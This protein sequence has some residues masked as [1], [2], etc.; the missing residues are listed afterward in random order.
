MGE[1]T[2]GFSGQMNLDNCIVQC[3]IAIQSYSCQCLLR[4]NIFV[5]IITHF[6]VPF[7]MNFSPIYDIFAYAYSYEPKITPVCWIRNEFFSKRGRFSFRHICALCTLSS[8]INKQ[9]RRAR[10]CRQKMLRARELTISIQ[11]ASF[12]AWPKRACSRWTPSAVCARAE[13][14]VVGAFLKCLRRHSYIGS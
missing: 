1:H 3:Y 11:N 7:L 13:R 12:A 9:N 2:S 6:V 5:Q 14:V 10:A 8:P 4:N